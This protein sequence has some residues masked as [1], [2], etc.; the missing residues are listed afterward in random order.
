MV[1]K[2]AARTLQLLLAYKQDGDARA[3]EQLVSNYVPLVRSLCRRFCTS[4]EPQ[5]D[6][7]QVGMIGLLN[8]IE[9]FDPGRGTS[10]ASLTIPEV[11]GAILNYLRD[12]GSLMKVPRTIRRNKLAMDKVSETLAPSLGHWPTFAELARECELS[13]GEIREAAELARVGAPRS[14]DERLESDDTESSST[15]SEQLGCEDEEFDLSLDRITLAAALDT[16]PTRER[17]ILKLRFYKELS[18][19]QI[20]ER[21]AISQM[22]VSRLER[23]ALHKLRVALQRSHAVPTVQDRGPMTSGSQLPAAS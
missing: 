7:F 19:R 5:E 21:I 20:A 23:A 10:F 13:E 6:L 8:A 3:R 16:L 15:L 4:R 2:S 14:L 22:H 12:H 11:L 17:K 18:Q 9:K 1:I